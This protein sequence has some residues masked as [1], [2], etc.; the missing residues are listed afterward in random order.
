MIVLVSKLSVAIFVVSFI[1][2]YG[3]VD[4]ISKIDLIGHA[5][6][7][8][9]VAINDK[10]ALTGA[11]DGTARIWDIKSGRC[12]REFVGH[13]AKIT[14]LGTNGSRVVTGSSDGTVKIWDKE[15]GN[16]LYTC[17]S[18]GPNAM[19]LSDNKLI[20]GCRDYST[21]VYDINSCNCLREFSGHRSQKNCFAVVRAVVASGDIIVTASWDGSVKFWSMDCG[22]CFHSLLCP[23][24]CIETVAIG[25]DKII[26]GLD[27]HTA[28]IWDIRSWSELHTLTGRHQRRINMIWVI[29]NNVITASDDAV[30]VWDIN[31]GEWLYG[32]GQ[33][34]VVAVSDNKIFTGQGLVVNDSVKVWD[35][36]GVQCLEIP[37][38]HMAIQ[39]IAAC[40]NKIITGSGDGT[41]TIWIDNRPAD[42]QKIVRAL[43]TASHPRCGLNSPARGLPRYLMEDIANLAALSWES[44]PAV[45]HEN[46][47]SWCTIC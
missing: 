13:N 39:A 3:G 23:D 21:K 31:T 16:C 34:S 2:L 12:L 18:G 37:T 29:G 35:L 36:T 15:S 40:G 17:I 32:C 43:A 11:V 45:H 46:P 19:L 5:G 42:T 20:I 30:Q 22:Q 33:C 6:S 9:A 7:I 38:G 44:A 41:A 25:K 26:A 10:E 8:T 1:S 27:D 4:G 24:H 47:D 14:A 28:K